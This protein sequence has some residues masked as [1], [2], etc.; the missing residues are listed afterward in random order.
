MFGDGT[1]SEHLIM[2]PDR[3]HTNPLKPDNI[4]FSREEGT[5]GAGYLKQSTMRDD[6]EVSIYTHFLNKLR[7]LNRE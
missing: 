7:R 6:L 4:T 2:Q 5:A 1:P 3:T